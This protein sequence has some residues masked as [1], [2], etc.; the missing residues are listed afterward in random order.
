METLVIIGVVSTALF[1]C[2]GAYHDIKTPERNSPGS[3]FFAALGTLCIVTNIAI[4]VLSFFR[5]S[6][7]IALAFSVCLVFVPLIPK[8]IQG[9]ISDSKIRRIPN[10]SPAATTPTVGYS[11]GQIAPDDHFED[12]MLQMMR[13]LPKSPHQHETTLTPRDTKEKHIK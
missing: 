11:P 12:A 9:I 5:T 4:M 13:K 1:I 10:E 3:M 8:M 7:G 2:A 6:A